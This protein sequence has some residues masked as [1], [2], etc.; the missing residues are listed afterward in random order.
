VVGVFYGY[1]AE[2]GV[3]VGL[4]GIAVLIAKGNY[5]AEG[6]VVVVIDCVISGNVYSV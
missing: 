1:L 6:V 4:D 5:R 2:D 3:F